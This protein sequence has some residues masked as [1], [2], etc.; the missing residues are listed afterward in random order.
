VVA[1]TKGH[2]LTDIRDEPRGGPGREGVER[3]G[4]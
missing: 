1:N 3:R 2:S 4:K